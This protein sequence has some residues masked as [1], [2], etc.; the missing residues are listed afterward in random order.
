MAYLFWGG[1]WF[2]VVLLGAILSN[3]GKPT[4]EQKKHQEN[5]QRAR[6]ILAAANE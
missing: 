5:Y 1:L 3:S 6:E 2:G 4:K